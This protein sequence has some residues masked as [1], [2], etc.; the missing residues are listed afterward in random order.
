MLSKIYIPSKKFGILPG[1]LTV[2]LMAL[3]QGA[4]AAADTDYKEPDPKV[5][6][7][8]ESTAASFKAAPS[9]KHR[10]V[11]V[12]GK[13]SEPLLRLADRN[14]DPEASDQRCCHRLQ[15]RDFLPSRE[16]CLLPRRQ[17][18]MGPGTAR[19]RQ[20]RRPQM[21]HPRVS[22]RVESVM[23]SECRSPSRGGEIAH[24]EN[25]CV[26]GI[27]RCRAHPSAGSSETRCQARARRRSA[28][29]VC[30]R[31]RQTPHL[32]SLS[33]TVSRQISLAVTNRREFS[34]RVPLPGAG[35]SRIYTQELA[36]PSKRIDWN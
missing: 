20:R 28:R 24:H 19:V 27:S 15:Q 4:I 14:E 13:Q 16:P 29:G 11:L 18:E 9:K 32:Q 3:C 36:R 23:N 25:E 6:A 10:R 7:R 31:H 8:V 1:I 5:I 33:I 17:D 12:Y 30:D 2:A 26:G 22:R 21:A 35:G 34:K